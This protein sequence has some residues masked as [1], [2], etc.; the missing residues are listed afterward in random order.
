MTE[1]AKSAEAS[2]TVNILDRND[3]SPVFPPSGYTVQLAEGEGRRD[4]TTVSYFSKWTPLDSYLKS[5]PCRMSVVNGRHIGVC[6]HCPYSDSRVR[7]IKGGNISSFNSLKRSVTLCINPPY[8][9]S[10]NHFNSVCDFYLRL[11]Q[12]ILQ[13][14][15][16][17]VLDSLKDTRYT[18][19]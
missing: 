9:W 2:V 17:Q 15:I 19:Y 16:H 7:I 12:L 1:G 10:T 14:K 18:W 11:L 8:I 13:L 5:K 6:Q 3:N 4:V